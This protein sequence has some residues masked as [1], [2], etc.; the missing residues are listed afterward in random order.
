MDFLPVS[1]ATEKWS[2]LKVDLASGQREIVHLQELYQ[3]LQPEHNHIGLSSI[4]DAGICST[5]Q[6]HSSQQATSTV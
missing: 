5:S 4:T 2:Q 1:Q 3:A 6:Y